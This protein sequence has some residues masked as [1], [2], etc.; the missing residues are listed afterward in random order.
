[1]GHSDNRRSWPDE[2]PYSGPG[3][4]RVNSTVSCVLT[5]F[6]LRSCWSLIAF[7]LAFRRVRHA[8]RELEGLL[9]AVFLMEDLRTCY[10][11]SFWEHDRAIVEFGRLRTHIEAANSAFRRTC[12][13]NMSRPEIWSAQF[14][15]WAVS[16]HNLN[17]EGLD[18]RSSLDEQWE[19]RTQ[20]GKMG[21]AIEVDP[22]AC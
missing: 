6:R 21:T 7:Y 14:R 11:L 18:L 3:F 4:A 12:C 10:T 9:E 8:A 16:C 13:G 1:M 15:L 22:D 5:R 2:C 17:W 20:V 19:R